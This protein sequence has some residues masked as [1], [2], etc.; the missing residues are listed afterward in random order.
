[1]FTKGKKKSKIDVSYGHKI[2]SYKIDLA[3][4]FL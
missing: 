4:S 2:L 3:M 1:M